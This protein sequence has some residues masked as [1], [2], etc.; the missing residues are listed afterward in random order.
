MDTN[1]K[2]INRRAIFFILALI[3]TILISVAIY[4]VVAYK[5]NPFLPKLITIT[6]C[7]DY[8]PDGPSS[9][10][11]YYGVDTEEGCTKIDGNA[12]YSYGWGKQYLGCE[13]R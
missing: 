13:P 6:S 12:V 2:S 3:V 7:S 5:Y 4:L 8:C 1:R 9:H 11:V 10:K